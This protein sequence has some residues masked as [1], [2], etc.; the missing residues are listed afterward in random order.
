LG[1]DSDGNGLPDA[2]EKAV[3]A[4]LGRSW[5]AGQIRPGDVYPGTGMTYQEVYL[6]GTYSVAPKDG[7]TLDILSHQGESPTL[8][9]TA[10]KGRHSTLQASS[11]LDGWTTVPF[12]MAP[13]DSA[14]VNGYQA[15]DTR[16]V[17]I[18]APPLGDQPAKFYRLMVE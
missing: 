6:A 12:R 7:F 17:E 13:A 11:S 16:R 4:Q 10:V 15:I 1:V 9:F 14:A 18:E 3:A 8:A 2:W 5:A